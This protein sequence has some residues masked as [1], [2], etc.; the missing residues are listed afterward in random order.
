MLPSTCQKLWIPGETPHPQP[1]SPWQAPEDIGVCLWA[2]VGLSHTRDHSS[3]IR[4][5][6]LPSFTPCQPT[7]KTHESVRV[8]EEIRDVNF[9][10]GIHIKCQL[11]TSSA[12]TNTYY[13]CYEIPEDHHLSQIFKH[14]CMASVAFNWR[15][16]WDNSSASAEDQRGLK[17]NTVDMHSEYIC[18]LQVQSLD[19]FSRNVF[20]LPFH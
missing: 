19:T 5:L 1:P 2:A 7:N 11:S 9:W 4:G 16:V 18:T 20:S 10:W 15:W 14:T 6:I 17:A 13:N 3:I 12:L 8:R